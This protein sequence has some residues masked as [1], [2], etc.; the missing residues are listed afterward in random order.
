M[1]TKLMAILL[2]AGGA[3]F[4]QPRVSIGV[5]IGAH[6]VYRPIRVAPV[7][8][9]VGVYRPP[10]PGPG[11]VWIDGYYDPYGAWLDGYWAYPPYAG[12]YWVTPRYYGGRYIAGYWGGPRGIYHGGHHF[13]GPGPAMRGPVHR[14]YEFRGPGRGYSHGY[15]RNYNHGHGPRR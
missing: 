10:C 11:Y 13:V 5:H 8:W 1:K 6:P 4:G 2:M 15:G 7:R 3:L 12:A 14:G 9:A